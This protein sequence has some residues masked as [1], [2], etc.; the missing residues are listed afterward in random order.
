MGEKTEK[1]SSK[2]LRDAKK[3]G[4]V[5]KSQDLP[6]AA[7]FIVSIAITIGMIPKLY[8]Q[9]GQMLVDCFSLVTHHHISEILGSVFFEAAYLIFVSTVPIVG[10]V[11]LI[12]MLV[13]FL[14]IGPVFAPDVFKFDIKKFNPID[15]LKAKFKMKTVVELLKSLL[16]I[17]VAGIIVYQVVVESIPSLIQSQTLPVVS[18]LRLFAY[19]LWEV[20]KRVG[21][22]FAAIAILD[23]MYQKYTFAQEMKM[24]KFEVKQEY[25]ETEGNPEIKGRRR[26]VAREIAYS[27][28]PAAGAAK[29]AAVVTNPTELAIA[30]GFEA[31]IDPCPYILAMGQGMLAKEIIRIAEKCNVPIVRNLPLAHALWDEAKLYE[32]I[33]EKTYEPVAE[34]MRWLAEMKH[35]ER[36][37]SLNL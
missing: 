25:K 32:Y 19:F 31:G 17:T 18:S 35:E 30:L 5:A 21:I 8:N 24:E 3:K 33:P 1:A 13:T 16:K 22:F 27:E 34:I 6:A 23:F 15:N 20:V 28:G 10:A 9:V 36:V 14:S 11:C 29:A 37:K 12:G 26:E 4:Q 7:T 2:K